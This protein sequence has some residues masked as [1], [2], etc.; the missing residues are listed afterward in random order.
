MPYKRYATNAIEAAILNFEENGG[1]KHSDCPA[2]DKTIRGWKEQFKNRG[3]AAVDQ[4][5]KILYE[6]YGRS[7]SMIKL[8]ASSLIERLKTLIEPFEPVS[9]D[10][11]IGA[12]NIILSRYSSGYI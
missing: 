7:V 10:S 11:L 12:V 4:L 9:G 8:I 2:E 6:Q 3:N 5:Q 1:L